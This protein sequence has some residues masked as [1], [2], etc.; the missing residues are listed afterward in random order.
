MT[1][2][3]KWRLVKTGLVLGALAWAAWTLLKWMGM[4]ANPGGRADGW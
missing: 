4:A 1:A 3:G 2:R